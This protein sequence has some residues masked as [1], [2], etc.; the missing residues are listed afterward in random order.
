[1]PELEKKKKDLLEKRSLYKPIDKLEILEHRRR[2][3][4]AVR[5]KTDAKKQERDKAAADWAV[6]GDPGKYKSKFLEDIVERELHEKEEKDKEDDNKRRRMEK[7]GNYAKFVKEMHWPK[8]SEEKKIKLEVLK[9]NLKHPVRQPRAPASSHNRLID[10]VGV[11]PPEKSHMSDDGVEANK[12]KLNWP[13]RP[14]VQKPPPEKRA[15]PSVDW[16][17]EQ[18][19]KR[20]EEAKQGMKQRAKDWER[21]L[22][23]QKLSEKE[24]YE[25]IKE[26]AKAIEADAKRRER[27]LAVKSTSNVDDTVEVNDMLIDA[28]KAKLSILDDI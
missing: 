6:K 24:R 3:E 10:N 16:L 21:H 12:R 27:I 4:E 8:V 26:K 7:M 28:I 9:E 23:D 19:L 2:Y 17:K 20:E 25:L 13:T 1:M 22:A 11:R 18:R 15:A 14:S 5:S